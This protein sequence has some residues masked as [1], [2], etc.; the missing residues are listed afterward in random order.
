MILLICGGRNFDDYGYLRGAMTMLQFNPSLIIEGGTTG[1]D[2]LAKKWAIENKIHFAEVPALW[3][4]FRNSAGPLRNA[5]MLLLKPDYCLALPGGKG[6]ADMV[7]KCHAEN[8]PCW[9]L[10]K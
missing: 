10:N 5:A 2:L 8:I 1:A 3:T 7:K 4:V 6:T 9:D